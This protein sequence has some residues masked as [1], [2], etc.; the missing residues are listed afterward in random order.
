MKNKDLLTMPAPYCES[1]ASLRLFLK[2]KE[3][4]GVSSVAAWS[5]ALA[6][7]LLL[8]SA[9]SV[10]YGT[11]GPDSVAALASAGAKADLDV[12]PAAAQ[13]LEEKMRALANPAPNTTA[14]LR[15]VTI[16]EA[17][18]NS[19]LKYR[20]QELLPPAVH[21][22]EVHIDSDHVSGVA[23]VD[24]NELNPQGQ[25]S[26]DWTT[27]AL[28]SIFTGRQRVAATSK[29]ETANGQGKVTIERA[30]IGNTTVPQVLVDWLLQNYV[31]KRY[32]ID[33]S[34]PFALPDHVTRIELS[35]GRALLLRSAGKGH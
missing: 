6:A 9:R 7:L 15:P 13:A 25:T 35:A 31:Q 34:K 3:N 8:I 29:L 24:F 23:N 28:T 17:E 5:A 19:Y 14:P 32:K 1:Q 27:R 16:T 2:G 18:A 11:P 33:L 22:P 30:S 26:G 12:S 20:S 21:D 10:W 4:A